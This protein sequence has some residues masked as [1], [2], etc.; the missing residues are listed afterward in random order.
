M[1]LIYK[2]LAIFIPMSALACL[3]FIIFSPNKGISDGQPKLFDSN[4]T[5]LRHSIIQSLDQALQEKRFK[6]AASYNAILS[7]EALVRAFRVLK[8]WEGVRDSETGF[9]PREIT[10]KPRWKADDNAADLY[11]YLLLASHYL[12]QKNEEMW[13]DIIKRERDVCGKMPCSFH[14]KPIKIKEKNLA[15]RIFGAAEYAKDGL[16]AITDRLGRGP[17]FE[18]MEEIMDVLI[19]SAYVETKSGK[20]SATDAEVNGDNLQV[21]TRLY[22]ATRKSKYLEMA[23]R[24]GDAYFFEVFPRNDYLPTHDWDF[25]KEA[26]TDKFFKIRDHGNEIVPGL[27]ELYFLEKTL[28]RVIKVEQYREPLKKFLDTLL[29]IGR[30]DQG[31]WICKIDTATKTQVNKKYTD[32]WG[33]ISNAYVTFDLAEGSQQYNLEMQRTMKAVAQI[34]SYDWEEKRQDGYADTIESMLYLLPWFDIRECHNWVDEEIGILFGKQ[35]ESGFVESIY[36]DGN[37]IRTALLYGKYKTLGVLP[38]PWREDLVLGSAFDSEKRWLYLFLNC[39]RDWNGL[40]KFDSPRHRL[41]WS[42]PFQYPRLNSSPEWFV[43]EP[44]K[45]YVIE[46]IDSGKREVRSGQSLIDGYAVN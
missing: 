30:N 22:W 20:I 25:N 34:K 24:I 42:L 33:Y 13:I 7:Q 36:L 14:F 39:E 18:R 16:L 41:I 29:R 27:V 45:K 6:D 8:A 31:I 11:P 12:D 26:P 19:D 43:V 17:W 10:G 15:T 40:L 38:S 23:E 5:D 32:N 9:V 4:Q 35:Q 44:E 2:L 28:G 46:N 3:V 21:L 1:R 37:F